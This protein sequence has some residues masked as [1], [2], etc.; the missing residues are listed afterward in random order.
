MVSLRQYQILNACA[1]SPELFYFLFAQVNYGGQVFPR[2]NGPGYA[3]YD[4]EREWTVTASAS[5]IAGD[6]LKLAARGLLDCWALWPRHRIDATPDDL[7]VYDDYRCL[8]FEDHV[9]QFGYGPHE[10]EATDAGIEE[11]HDASNAGNA[12]GLGWA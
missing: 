9:A 8:T 2:G 6:V 7:L 5:E 3:Q 4:D 10:F 1:D 12:V 11:I